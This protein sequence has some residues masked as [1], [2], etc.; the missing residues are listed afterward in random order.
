MK[1][2]CSISVLRYVIGHPV[3]T[4][5]PVKKYVSGSFVAE[6]G[7]YWKRSWADVA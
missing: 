7:G 6:T 3:L 5:R 2:S 1:Y 4:N